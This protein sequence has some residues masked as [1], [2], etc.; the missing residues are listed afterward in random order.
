[1]KEKIAKTIGVLTVVA[2]LFFFL[3]GENGTFHEAKIGKMSSSLSWFNLFSEK[4]R[5]EKFQ[6]VRAFIQDYSVLACESIK[7]SGEFLVDSF[8]SLKGLYGENNVGIGSV[9][10]NEEFIAEGRAKVSGKVALGPRA[11]Y[12]IAGRAIVGGIEKVSEDF[13]CPDF[14]EAF[15]R[16]KVQNDNENIP[17]EY[18]E[19]GSLNIEDGEVLELPSGV[20][21]LKSLKLEGKAKL[22][23]SGISALFNNFV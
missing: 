23:F 6:K 11:T 14:E 15:L 12:K 17:K 16:A 9:A 4:L 2:G 19:N 5:N 8:V 13:L 21:Y 7:L 20:Y 18:Y 22:V 10:T 3:C 1:M